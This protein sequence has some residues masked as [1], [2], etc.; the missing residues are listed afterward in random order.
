MV[1]VTRLEYKSVD[2]ESSARPISPGRRSRR[3][4]QAEQTRREILEA[5][6]RRFARDGYAAT[7]L[8]DIAGDAGVSVQTIYDS[9]GSKADLIRGLNDLVDR[10]ADVAGIT[11]GIRDEPDPGAL[12]AIPARVTA[13]LLD[14][15]GDIL[16]ACL[17]GGVAE[18][19][20]VPLIEE[21]GRRHREGAALIA[22]RLA[23][24]GALAP[25]VTVEQAATSLA[26]LSDFRLGIVLMDDHAMSVEQ[27]ERWMAE[28]GARAVLSEP[29]RR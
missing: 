18:T 3:A 19:G 29:S 12:A 25:A 28:Q 15:C 14:R 21:G 22:N 8:R 9:V 13:R 11:A 20:L 7:S 1:Q 4:V 24:L 6:R 23:S 16:R 2:R 5:A 26:A 17:A 27:I 10:E